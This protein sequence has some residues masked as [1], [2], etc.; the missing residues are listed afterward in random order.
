MGNNNHK[1]ALFL[2]ENAQF[3]ERTGLVIVFDW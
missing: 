2:L 1:E 3:T